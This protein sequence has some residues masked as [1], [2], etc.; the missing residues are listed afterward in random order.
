V[1]PVLTVHSSESVLVLFSYQKQCILLLYSCFSFWS[2][3]GT[4]TVHFTFLQPV[5]FGVHFTANCGNS[6]LATSFGYPLLIGA[7]K[8]WFICYFALAAN[9]QH[10]PKWTPTACNYFCGYSCVSVL[11]LFWCILLFC[12]LY[13]AS[14]DYLVCSKRHRNIALKTNLQPFGTKNSALDFFGN[15]YM[16]ELYFLV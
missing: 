5:L 9:L 11:V 14:W 8:N 2:F 15:V 10:Y 13:L 12:N 16:A 7:L 1:V 6:L 3:F 4:K